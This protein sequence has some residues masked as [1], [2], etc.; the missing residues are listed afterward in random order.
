VEALDRT[1]TVSHVAGWWTLFP[2]IGLGSCE[3]AMSVFLIVLE[4]AG[5]KRS[6][7]QYRRETYCDQM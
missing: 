3:A 2:G 5:E 6:C 1:V 4:I 7:G